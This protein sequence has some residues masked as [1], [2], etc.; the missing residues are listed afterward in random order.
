LTG[1][2]P[3]HEC[4]YTLGRT[5]PGTYVPYHINRPPVSAR[6]AA[7]EAGAVTGLIFLIP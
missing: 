3:P 7:L 4:I 6:G 5:P 1:A 2:F